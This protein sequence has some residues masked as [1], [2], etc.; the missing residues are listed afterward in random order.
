MAAA[1]SDGR[2]RRK[3]HP[4]NQIIHGEVPTN[5]PSFIPVRLF[6]ENGDKPS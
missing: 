5:P 3:H 2:Q 6:G 4:T 1:Q